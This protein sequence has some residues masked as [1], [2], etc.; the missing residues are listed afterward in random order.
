MSTEL[1]G[2]IHLNDILTESQ[3][4]RRMKSRSNKLEIKQNLRAVF[5]DMEI[6]DLIE[7][8]N[9]INNYMYNIKGRV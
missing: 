7:V 2:V 5:K 4:E 6:L 8:V 3:K 9:F 1:K